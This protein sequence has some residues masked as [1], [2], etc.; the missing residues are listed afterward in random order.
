VKERRTSGILL[1]PTSLPGPYGIGDIGPE[2][3]RF[4]D[5]LVDTGQGLWQVLPLGP[6]GYGNSPYQTFSAFA[7]N[8][9]LISPEALAEDGLATPTALR[10]KP[11]FPRDRV[12]YSMVTRFKVPLL[13]E[14]FRRFTAGDR[15][16]GR[17]EYDDF[18]DEHAPWLEDFALFM[19]L[20][21]AH[22]GRPWPQ[23]EEGVALAKPE[24]IEEWRRKLRP[25]VEFEKFAQ[26]LFFRQWAA[27]KR[28][29]NQAGVE[30]LGDLPIYVAH[31][32]ADVWRHRGYFQLDE[33]G[34]PTVVAGV[35]PDYFSATGQRWGN[36]IYR[37]EAMAADGY[38]WWIERLRRTLA[39]VDA[40]RLDHFRGFEAYWEIPADGDWWDATHG[41]WVPGPGAAL[42]EAA[43]RALGK[44]PLIA[45]DLGVITKEVD[46]LRDRLGFPGMRVLQMAFGTDPKAPDH[47]PHNHVWN[48]LVYTGT[49][50]N[51]T[52]VGWFTGSGEDTTNTKEEIARERE[53]ALKYLG[54]DGREIHWDFIRMAMASVARASIFP[55]QDVLG[56]GGE[57]RI[58][59][60]GTLQG[61]WEWRLS[62]G[63]LTEA[64]RE[65]LRELTAI[66]ERSNSGRLYSE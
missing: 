64:I 27:L 52:T 34:N 60:P 25:E 41:R 17:G 32:S 13:R 61:N 54:T 63:A 29:C 55:L 57:A 47:R 37:W 18:F 26:F 49:H 3:L 65:R 20:R 15:A 14:A 51:N 35:P 36:P 43:Q 30:I 16:M 21:E 38:R 2:A 46:A 12:D 44:L 33:T 59:R 23:W 8:P 53:Y 58:N 24:A 48:C 66:Y 1:H 4:V 5:F 39:L 56:L 22:Q 42:F 6:T 7:G 62:P 45:E 28:Y 10:R 40:I 31:N 50:D 9:L 19:A 11:R